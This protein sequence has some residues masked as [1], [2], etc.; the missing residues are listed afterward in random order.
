MRFKPRE[1]CVQADSVLRVRTGSATRY[2]AW[3]D[4]RDQKT[5][6]PSDTTEVSFGPEHVAT[7]YVVRRPT[8]GG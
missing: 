5:N 6:L 1:R 8:E 2:H 3:L 7:V 4:P